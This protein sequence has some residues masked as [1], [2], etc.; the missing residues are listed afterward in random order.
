MTDPEIHED[1]DVIVERESN[2]AGVIIAVVALLVMLAVLWYLLAGPRGAGP[3]S[4][5]DNAPGGAKPTQQAPGQSA[6]AQSAPPASAPAASQ[7]QS[8]G[9]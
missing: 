3:S 7:N 1:R 2:P 5:P 9:Y 8:P 6:P 4:N